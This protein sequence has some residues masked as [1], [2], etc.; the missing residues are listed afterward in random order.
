MTLS[1]I[2]RQDFVLEVSSI[3]VFYSRKLAQCPGNNTGYLYDVYV[4]RGITLKQTTCRS[5]LVLS[6]GAL[7]SA[8]PDP[9]AKQWQ[10]MTT[11]SSRLGMFPGRSRTVVENSGACTDLDRMTVLTHNEC[12]DPDCVKQ[13][14]SEW[15]SVSDRDVWHI[16][17]CGGG[18]GSLRLPYHLFMIC[19]KITTVY[20]KVS[21]L[22]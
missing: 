6:L 15:N 19:L 12:E 21:G 11:Y 13:S 1:Q 4:L 9:W 2:Q 14:F 10:G 17:V 16:Y 3:S 7:V 20:P 22:I 18:R 5:H 8:D